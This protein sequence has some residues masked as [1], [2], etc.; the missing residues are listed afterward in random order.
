MEAPPRPAG[1]DAVT[2]AEEATDHDINKTNL[3]LNRPNH[4]AHNDANNPLVQRFMAHVDKEQ[5]ENPQFLR[6][7]TTLP[8]G[9]P[10]D[11]AA[12]TIWTTSQF[13]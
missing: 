9:A 1:H 8:S 2:A 3:D 11:A 4:T 13:R 10:A 5:R 7:P 6:R 12:A